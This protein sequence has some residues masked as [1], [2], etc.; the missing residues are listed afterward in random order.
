MNSQNTILIQADYERI[1]ELA[2]RV[3]DWGRIL[4]HY[5]YVRVLKRD[6]ARTWL[7]MSARRDFIFFSWPV[8]WTA[9]ATV[10]PGSMSR[11]GR[12]VFH[13]TGGLVRGMDVAWTFEPRPRRG[14]VIVRITHHLHRPAFPVRI[15]GRRGVDVVVGKLFIEYIAGKTLKRIKLLAEDQSGRNRQ[16]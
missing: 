14:D 6:G 2:S 12:V 4:P 8:T 13:H 11:P 15:L 3:E 9:V 1:F 5:R 10:I 7:K 16:P